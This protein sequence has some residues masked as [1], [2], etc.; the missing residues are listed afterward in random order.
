MNLIL[1][2]P[3]GAG[4]GTQAKRVAEAYGL[5]HLSSGDI[6]RAERKAGTELGKKAQEYMDAG[7]LVP[8]D[9]VVSMMVKQVE[10]PEAAGGVLLDGFPRT[11]A[12]AEALDAKLA[13]IGKKIDLVIDL[14]V[15]DD[16]VES[17]L[18]GRRS[19]PTCGAVYHLRFHPPKT[20]GRCDK[21]DCGEL[22]IRPDDTEEVVRQR[23][24]TYH[25]QTEPLAAYYRE[26]GLLREVDGSKSVDEV[27][28]AVR[29]VCDA[30]R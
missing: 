16:D 30:A 27:T 11:R 3:P 20:E 6:L 1:L 22:T 28:S 15:P 24:R 12:Q 10:K 5:L 23:L 19:C 7:T 9:L 21:P 8:D 4:K 26:K 25:E 2:G 13:Q 29:E 14:V 18:T 17:R